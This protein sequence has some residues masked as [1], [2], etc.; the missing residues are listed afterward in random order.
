MRPHLLVAAVL[1]TFLV[2]PGASR[3]RDLTFRDRVEAQRAIERVYYSHQTGATIPFE[4]AV[5]D[6]VLERKVR[7]YLKQSVALEK[8]WKTPITASMLDAEIDRM[9][10]TTRMPERLNE[11][12][13]ALNNDRL[14]IRECLARPVLAGRLLRSFYASDGRLH[15]EARQ[16][17]EQLRD[18]MARKHAPAPET[19]EPELLELTVENPEPEIHPGVGTDDPQGPRRL[20][21]SQG[22]F[23]EWRRRLLPQAGE[24][25]NVAEEKER[26][27]VSVLL[28]D[29]RDALR[30]ATYAIPKRSFESWWAEVAADLNE[31]LVRIED[32]QYELPAAPAEPGKSPAVIEAV[33]PAAESAPGTCMVDNVWSAAKLDGDLPMARSSFTAVWTGSRMILWGGNVTGSATTNTGALYDPATDHWTPTSLIGA[34]SPR[35]SHVAVWS[36]DRMIIWS[37]STLNTGGRYDPASDTWT[38]TSTTNAPTARTYATAVWTGDR[39]V[40]WGGVD[41][42]GSTNTGGRYDPGS[43]TWS[44]TSL[45]SAP[46]GRFLHTAVWGAGKMVIW[47][48]LTVAGDIVNDGARYDPVSNTWSATSLAGAPAPRFEH[49]AIWTGASMLVWGGQSGVQALQTGGRYDP[50]SN[51][52]TSMATA[53]APPPRGNPAAVW[54]G[55]RLVI[56][57]GSA[58]SGPVNTGGRYDPGTDSWQPMTIAGAPSARTSHQGVWTGSLIVIWGGGDSN[59]I[60]LDTGGRYDPLADSWTPTTLGDAPAPRSGHSAIWTGNQMVVWGGVTNSGATNTGG[61]YDPVINGWQP[62]ALTGA[63]SA[64]FNN[65]VVWTG[66]RMV[67][68]GGR[69]GPGPVSD[70][71]L[72]DPIGDSWVATSTA[73]AP[74]PRFLHASVWTGSS[75]IVW[76]G[77]TTGG[78]D[79]N[80]GGRFDPVANVW[81]TTSTIGAPLARNRHTAVWTG[82][83]AIFWGGGQG[84]GPV[85]PFFNTGGRY[86]PATDSWSPT[87][88]TSAPAGRIEH[89][90]VW[91]GTR[92]IVWGGSDGSAIVPLTCTN[93]LNTGGV[94]NPAMDTWAA[95]P[96]VQATPRIGHT[97]V[98]AGSRMI[99]WGG[100]YLHAQAPALCHEMTYT[101]LNDGL[102]YRPSP[103]QWASVSTPSAPTPRRYHSAVWTGAWMLVWGGELPLNSDGGRLSFGQLADSDSDGF[104]VCEGDCNDLDPAIRPG[105]AEQCNGI[106]DDCDGATDEGLPDADG[107][108]YKICFDCNDSNPAV[109]PGAAEICNG[110]DDNCVGGIDEGPDQDADGYNSCTDCQDQDP[111]IHPGAAEVCNQSDDDCDGLTDEGFDQDGDGHSVCQGDCNE[112]DPG[113]WGLPV[114]AMELNVGSG[115]PTP[116]DW[117]DQ[118]PFLGPGTTYDLASGTLAGGGLNVNSAVCLQA[119]GGNSYLDTRPDPALGSGTWYLSRARNSCGIGSYGFSSAGSERSV[120]ACP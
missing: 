52:W 113:A 105:V 69:V 87:S 28:E 23:R 81:S 78:A 43:D 37:G 58:D 54:T 42:N 55:A 20:T 13:A 25:G 76:G 38:P 18:E 39:M 91:T 96:A 109:H 31:S 16:R 77:N 101:Y 64:R 2:T 3:T 94:Y 61:R 80:T 66:N 12:Y 112:A 118:G 84:G 83:L 74:L 56:W 88:T 8:Y 63:P 68:W 10:S 34:P 15:A 57:G 117:V 72:Y 100:A 115:S 111:A 110:V 7:T 50:A 90:A 103:G 4:E 106:D 46:T 67:I 44:P 1:A 95:T 22:E 59:S 107:D 73:N 71:A 92:M 85:P 86:N 36:G 33:L 97:A 5:P 19:L 98:W 21:V 114:E 75:M 89:T 119:A 65:T 79:T 53:G 60:L 17:A 108:G 26:F 35:S 29:R 45:A 41:A 9:R 27:T 49:V 32:E 6:S 47:G 51:Q 104:T 48:G 14:L 99:I 24:V 120:P 62:T 82:S 70:G 40:V 11:L 93:N 116:I 30:V 102:I